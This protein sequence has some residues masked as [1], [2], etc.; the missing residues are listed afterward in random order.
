MHTLAAS[1]ATARPADRPL[2]VPRY[3]TPGPRNPVLLLRPSWSWI[4]EL[5]GDHGLGTLIDERPDMVL[6]VAVSGA[7]PDVDT[8]EDLAR[9]E[10]P[11]R[12]KKE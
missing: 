1:A 4:D 11:T 6:E 5:K 10:R 8:A 12:A 3:Q 7:M 2:V 9:A